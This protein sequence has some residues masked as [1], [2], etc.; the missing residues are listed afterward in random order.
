V[1]PGGKS[2]IKPSNAAAAVLFIRAKVLGGPEH[3]MEK[4]SVPVAGKALEKGG[5]ALRCSCSKDSDDKGCA[6]LATDIIISPGAAVVYLELAVGF[7][8][9]GL[10]ISD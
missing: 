1:Q 8:Q 3:D 10:R 7:Y 9:S 2:R 6:E 4:I 5:A